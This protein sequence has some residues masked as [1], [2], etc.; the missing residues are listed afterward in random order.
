LHRWVGGVSPS[1]RDEQHARGVFIAKASSQQ[2]GYTERFNQTMERELFGHE[3]Y[4]VV[5]LQ[6]VVDEWTEKD[7]RRR[8]HRSL[9]EGRRTRTRGWRRVRL[10]WSH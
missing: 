2:S 5:E 10:P 9:V 7:E 8:P 1:S 6:H 4:S 3:I